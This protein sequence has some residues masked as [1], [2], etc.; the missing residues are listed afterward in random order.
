MESQTLAPLSRLD[1]LYLE[2][3]YELAARGIG[4]TAPNPP[5]GAVVVRDGC[6]VGEGYHHRA[7]A[8]HAETNALAQAG[9]AARS[10]TL[11]ISLEPCAVAGR[12]PAC[13]PILAEAGI[14]RVVCGTGDPNPR[15]AGRGIAYLRAHGVGVDIA[16]DE[17]A[18]EL[19]AIFAG[20]VASARSFVALKMAMSLDGAITSRQGVQTWLT[21]DAVRAYV[22]ELRVAYDAVMVGA[23]TVRVDDPQLTV[24]PARRR[25]RPF[26]RVVACETEPVAASSRIFEPV[27]G[28]APT[29]V[30]APAG[31]RAAYAELRDVATVLFVGSEGDLRLDLVA[32]MQALRANDIFSVVCE[33]GPTL[34][35]RLIAAGV[36]DAFYWAVAPILL[37]GPEAVPVLAGVDFA[38]LRPRLRIESTRRVG[39][40]VVITGSLSHV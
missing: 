9:D 35:A 11:Y 39:D 2:R 20:S 37:G 16:G 22:R 10:A 23:G 19:I 24:R 12:V 38:A 6:V 26:V 3:A 30:L 14:A 21:S 18:R 8:P 36:V 13:A 34:G 32:A 4:N 17:R 31:M 7:G 15:N 29:V 5:V 1:R 33:G 40:D 25:V 27:E 28:Y